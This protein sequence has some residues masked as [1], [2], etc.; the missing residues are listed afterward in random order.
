MASV[1]I[2]RA[3]CPE[4]G[5]KA[6]HVKKS[7]K[8]HYRYCPECGSQHYA[9]SAA[10]VENL[11]KK[12]RLADATATGTGSPTHTPSTTTATET[13]T[14]VPE[15]GTATPTTTPPAPRRHGIGLFQ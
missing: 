2:G 14:T 13:A 6:A 8:C 3:E 15:T 7:D 4:C 11:L 5:F 1:M 12:T 9:K 10:Q